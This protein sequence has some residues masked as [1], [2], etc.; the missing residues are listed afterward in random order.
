MYESRMF[1]TEHSYSYHNY[2]WSLKAMEF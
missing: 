2:Y 1:S